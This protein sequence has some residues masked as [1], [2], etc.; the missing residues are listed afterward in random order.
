[1]SLNG[2][3]SMRIHKQFSIKNFL[4]INNL[5]PI[6]GQ[7]INS[8]RTFSQYKKIDIKSQKDIRNITPQNTTLNSNDI[9]NLIIHS[10]KKPMYKSQ[11]NFFVSNISSL[12]T[13][14]NFEKKEKLINKLIDSSN[15]T[16]TNYKKGK[17]INIIN[18]S[19][20]STFYNS[21]ENSNEYKTLTIQRKKANKI[22]NKKIKF[23]YLED[24]FSKNNKN[25][26]P[27]KREYKPNLK[28][29]FVNDTLEQY[30]KK[31]NTIR[32]SN[33]EI[34]NIYKDSSNLYNI[35]INVGKKLDALRIAQY[36]KIKQIK[37]MINKRNEKRPSK[38]ILR[39]KIQR[40]EISQDKLFIKKKYMDNDFDFEIKKKLNLKLIYKNGYFSNSFKE[41]QNRIKNKISIDVVKS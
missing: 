24:Y 4:M 1:M 2:I 14:K 25:N 22:A 34:T 17:L 37:Q 13:I 32:H 18:F 11:K 3:K 41:I 33:N 26:E 7:K 31:S 12:K 36:R 15:N 6:K 30:N 27:K 21:F 38:K 5:T 8:L 40:G 35:I 16:C 20:I 29:F 23:G 28:Y 10:T 9:S 39:L 19:K